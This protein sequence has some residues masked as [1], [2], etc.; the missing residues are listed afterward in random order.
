M[1]MQHLLSHERRKYV[2]PDRSGDSMSLK[3]KRR[4]A[5]RR[6]RQSLLELHMTNS[7]YLYP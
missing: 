3:E 2:A 1:P 7:H 5:L 6:R 4:A